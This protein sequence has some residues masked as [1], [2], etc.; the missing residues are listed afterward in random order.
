MATT[1]SLPLHHL[2][3]IV[4]S[5]GWKKTDDETKTRTIAKLIDTRHWIIE[6]VSEAVRVQADIVLFLDTPTPVCLYRCVR[7]CLTVGFASRPE[8]PEDCPEIKI[9]WR[10]VKIV[11][12]F[13][14]TQ[15]P[16]LV[17]E[18]QRSARVQ[19][20]TSTADAEAALERYLSAP[21]R[22]R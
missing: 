17:N 20:C 14:K 6:G 21:E 9:L 18:A 4:W 10:V 1:H 7:R 15:R 2:D 22:T 12:R 8:L 19:R 5:A 13:A 3:Q 16:L 11:L